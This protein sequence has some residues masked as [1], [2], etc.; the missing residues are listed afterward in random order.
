LL[1]KWA[2][3]HICTAFIRKNAEK[4]GGLRKKSENCSD[5]WYNNQSDRQDFYTGRMI[6]RGNICTILMNIKNGLRLPA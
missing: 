1:T 6:K 3:T 5:L 2:N 4:P